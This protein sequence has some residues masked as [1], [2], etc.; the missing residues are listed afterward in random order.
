[1]SVFLDFARAAAQSGPRMRAAI[2]RIFA[3]FQPAPE[4]LRV[5]PVEACEIDAQSRHRGLQFRP[6]RGLERQ[7]AP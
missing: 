3:L 7:F 2:S 4:Q 6:R 1:M 5:G